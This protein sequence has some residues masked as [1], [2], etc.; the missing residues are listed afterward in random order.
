MIQKMPR[1]NRRRDES[2]DQESFER[3]LAGF[4]RTE[5]RRG[6]EW[7]V[8]PISAQ[9]AQKE[10]QCPGCTVLILPGVAHIVAWRADGVLGESADVADR[11]HWHTRCW[12]MQ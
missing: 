3:L 9:R 5:F 11:R 4:K 2:Y 6:R 1:S 8:Q 7:N 12:E 10:Y